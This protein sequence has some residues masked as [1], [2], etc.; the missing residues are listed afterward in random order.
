MSSTARLGLVVAA[1]ALLLLPAASAGTSGSGLYGVVKKGPITP[2][3]RVDVPC[4]APV[5]VT[6]V[7]SRGGRE[8]ARVRSSEKGRYRLGLEPGFY[9]VRSTVRIGIQKLPKPHAL[10][11]RAGHWD[12]INLFFDTGIR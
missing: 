8:V 10:H 7:F 11:V 5:K 9:D 12:K 4:D 6:L 1:A 3:C 2:V